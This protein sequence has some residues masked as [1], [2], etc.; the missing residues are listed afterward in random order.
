MQILMNGENGTTGAPN[1]GP[2]VGPGVNLPGFTSATQVTTAAGYLGAL[3]QY[4]AQ[5]NTVPG[6]TG[7]HGAYAGFGAYWV[8]GAR[9][10]TGVF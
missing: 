10:H 9:L 6:L 1:P 5:G 2:F 4:I 3:A 8:P 7:L